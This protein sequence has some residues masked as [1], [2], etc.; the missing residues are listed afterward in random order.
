MQR[1]FESEK[2]RLFANAASP[3]VSVFSRS[4]LEK[5]L[6]AGQIVI[7]SNL[8]DPMGV[9]QFNVCCIAGGV[10]QH[11]VAVKLAP[12]TAFEVEAPTPTQ[13]TVKACTVPST[14]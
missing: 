5:C 10:N 4:F 9:S 13:A 11:T 7:A 14:R 3:M 12:H 8:Q 2:R 1:L 6:A